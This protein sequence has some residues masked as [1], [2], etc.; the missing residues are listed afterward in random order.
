MYTI[1]I[2]TMELSRSHIYILCYIY[3]GASVTNCRDDICSPIEIILPGSY[4]VRIYG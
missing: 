3:T 1:L 4:P 2:I